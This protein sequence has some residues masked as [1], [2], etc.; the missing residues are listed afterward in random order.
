MLLSFLL[1]PSG[2]KQ[3]V[4]LYIFFHSVYS[5]RIFYYYYKVQDLINDLSV[6]HLRM[7]KIIII[8]FNASHFVTW[9]FSEL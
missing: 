6:T 1:I 5:Q 8:Y 9:L 2:C 7:L 3:K 4:F